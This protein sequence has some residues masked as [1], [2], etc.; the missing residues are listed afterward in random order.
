MIDEAR[1]V[2]R[3]MKDAPFL[4]SEPPNDRTPIDAPSQRL[5]VSCRK[6]S[7]PMGKSSNVAGADRENASD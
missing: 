2:K 3:F 7:C 4:A 5:S 6:F 1:V